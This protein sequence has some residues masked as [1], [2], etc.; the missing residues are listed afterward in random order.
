MRPHELKLATVK[1]L[2]DSFHLLVSRLIGMLMMK[3]IQPI[4]KIEHIILIQK[5]VPYVILVKQTLVAVISLLVIGKSV[6]K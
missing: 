6:A 5:Q 1:E 3:T 2:L 4:L